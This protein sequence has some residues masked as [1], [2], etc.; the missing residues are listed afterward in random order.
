[1]ILRVTADAHEPLDDA[2]FGLTPDPIPPAIVARL[3]AAHRHSPLSPTIAIS[4]QLGTF[5]RHLRADGLLHLVSGP[6]LDLHAPLRGPGTALKRLLA[7]IGIVTTPRC[8]CAATARKMDEGGP[9][10]CRA[11]LDEIV[12]VMAREAKARSLPFSRLAG[13]AL[14]RLAIRLAR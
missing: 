9:D 13:K 12:D 10:W 4:S 1:M 14:V 5:T 11:H 8:A 2:D 3:I 6:Y 7:A